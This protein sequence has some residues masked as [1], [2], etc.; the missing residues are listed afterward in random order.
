MDL[1]WRPLS[2]TPY[3]YWTDQVTRTETMKLII[4]NFTPPPG[5]GTPTSDTNKVDS[6]QHE[7]EKITTV[8]GKIPTNKVLVPLLD[9]LAPVDNERK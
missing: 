8:L 7:V 5:I 3:E 9:R 4:K 2:R 1:D 6:Q